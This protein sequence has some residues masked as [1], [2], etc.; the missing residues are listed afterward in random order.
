MASSSISGTGRRVG[1]MLAVC[2]LATGSLLMTGCEVDSFLDPSTIGRWEKTPTSVPILERLTSIEEDSGEFVEYSDP[3]AQDLIPEPSDYRLSPGDQVRVTAFDDVRSNAA[4]SEYDREVDIRGRIN[5]PQI[6]QVELT[7]LTLDQARELIAERLKKFV[8]DPLVEVVILQKRQQTFTVVGAVQQ[9]GPYFIPKPDYRLYEAI[10]A[11]GQFNETIEYIYVVRQVPL[12]DLIKG[13]MARPAAAPSTPARPTTEPNTQPGT[14]PSTQPTT[15]P[16]ENLIDLIDELS[17]P[18]DGEKAKDPAS[19]GGSPGLLRPA[20]RQ[21]VIEPPDHQEPK[22]QEPVI[23]LVDSGLSPTSAQAPAEGG[24]EGASA[25]VFLEGRWVQVKPAAAAAETAAQ[26]GEL[27]P[28]QLITQRVIRVP[29]KP[30]LDGSAQFNV[31]IRP[32][33]IVRIP[34]APVGVFYMEGQVQRPGPYSIPDVGRMTLTRAVV[35]AGGLSSLAVPERVDLTRMVGKDRQA[36]IRLDLRAVKEG[37]MPDIYLKGDDI[38]NVGTNFWAY[39]LA[40]VRNG[41]R[42]TYGFGFVLDR[43]FADD[44]FGPQ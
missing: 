31:V 6:G 42:A 37:T 12:S 27:T 30:L 39:P 1:T 22:A 14:Q 17:K 10:T 28:D 34:T 21:P 15:Q 35:S 33:D 24:V 40:V 5:M 26:G 23:D 29:L 36:T 18:K 19:G 32:G 16:A 2:G 3:S 4:A 20:G 11:A 43:N 25:W 41:F 44:V 13:N 8:N 38:V 9:P 7:G